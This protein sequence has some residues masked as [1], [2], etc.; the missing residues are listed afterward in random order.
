L[1]YDIVQ[2][3]NPEWKGAV[4]RV[5]I[6]RQHRQTIQVSLS[7]LSLRLSGTDFSSLVISVYS[8]SRLPRSWAS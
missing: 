2:S 6:F 1:D 5:N 7:F 8:T 3:T 4:V